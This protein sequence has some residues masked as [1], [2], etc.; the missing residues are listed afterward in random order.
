MSSVE[1]APLSCLQAYHDPNSISLSYQASGTFSVPLVSICWGSSI[2]GHTKN[3]TFDAS[4]PVAV[5]CDSPNNTAIRL[6]DSGFRDFHQGGV[7]FGDSRQVSA[8][9]QINPNSTCSITQDLA[10]EAYYKT[11]EDMGDCSSSDQCLTFDTSLDFD[12][13]DPASTTRPSPAAAIWI[14]YNAKVSP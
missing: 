3:G 12:V 6:Q 9:F 7:L 10:G 4:N 11:C 13:V 8:E 14:E 2:L 5:R 1:R